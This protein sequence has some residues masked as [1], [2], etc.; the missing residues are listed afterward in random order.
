MGKRKVECNKFVA[1]ANTRRSTYLKRKKGL[2]KKAM[3]LSM[4]C[5]LTVTLNVYDYETRRLIKYESDLNF[6]RQISSK[7][8]VPQTIE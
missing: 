1:D 5:G 8:L 7:K 6:D 2:I 4:M 3:E